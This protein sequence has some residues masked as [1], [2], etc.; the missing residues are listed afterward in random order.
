MY[1]LYKRVNAIP[2][3]RLV[4]ELSGFVAV[5]KVVTVPLNIKYNA[6]ENMNVYL[7]ALFG[8]FIN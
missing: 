7:D 4:L 2:F 6:N 5:V 8:F 1:R 3:G